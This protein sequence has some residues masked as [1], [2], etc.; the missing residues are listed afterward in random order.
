MRILGNSSSSVSNEISSVQSIILGSKYLRA[1]Q[2]FLDEVVN[3][4]KGIIKKK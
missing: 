4:G 2:E 3:V 1:A